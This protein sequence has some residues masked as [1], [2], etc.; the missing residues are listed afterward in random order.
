M[1]GAGGVGRRGSI[2]YGRTV[3]VGAFSAATLAQRRHR[4]LSRTITHARAWHP[5]VE[6]WP[7]YVTGRI[8]AMAN[9][10][11]VYHFT[12]SQSPT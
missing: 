7:V 8:S 11:F 1:S 9:L 12:T 6:Q 5:T 4:Y 3:A 10:L 2:A